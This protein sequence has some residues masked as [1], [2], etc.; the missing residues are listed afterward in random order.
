MSKKRKN[1]FYCY[2]LLGSFLCGQSIVFTHYHKETVNC[3][4]PAYKHAVG[5]N[6]AHNSE[7]EKC[8]LCSALLHKVLF[9]SGINTLTFYPVIS[10]VTPLQQV[11]KYYGIE[12]HIKSRAP[13]II[14]C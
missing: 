13:P 5:I 10:V 6:H 9:L 1:I 12:K 14:Y 3:K 8:L 11:K 7:I 2:L 4:V